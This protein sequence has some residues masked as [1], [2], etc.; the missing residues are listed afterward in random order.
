MYSIKNEVR[1]S[2]NWFVLTGP[3]ISVQND[4]T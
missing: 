4:D 3:L 1:L 2:N